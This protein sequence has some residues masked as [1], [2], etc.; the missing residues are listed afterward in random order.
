MII[1]NFKECDLNEFL[2]LCKEF[3]GS[4][5]T[6]KPFDENKAKNTFLR[7]IE[8]HENLWGYFIIDSE[9]GNKV[10]YSLV[11]SYWCNEEGGN[12]LVLDELY[13]SPSSR[14]HGYGGKFMEWLENEFKGKAV[15]LTLEVL[16]TNQN[17]KSLYN[18][19]G[20]VPDGFV[21]YTKNI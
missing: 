18:K 4:Y 2:K 1:K 6:I 9:N 19:E 17:A 12:V 5:S 10:G 7:V 15:S 20:L 14:H 21:T 3:Y 16:T 11:T 13:I 8:N